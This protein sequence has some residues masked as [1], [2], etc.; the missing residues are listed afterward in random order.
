MKF[1]RIYAFALKPE[2]RIRSMDE[3]TANGLTFSMK[4]PKWSQINQCAKYANLLDRVSVSLLYL[5]QNSANNLKSLITQSNS[6][7]C[8]S[9]VVHEIR[10]LSN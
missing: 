7:D 3:L 4:L 9:I 2:I 1:G 5:N 8:E 6:A 10:M